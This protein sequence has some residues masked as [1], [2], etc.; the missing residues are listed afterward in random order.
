MKYDFKC[1]VCGWI[2]EFH[3]PMV[4]VEKLKP[5]CTSCEDA[6]GPIK[7]KRIWSAPSVHF[8]GTGWTKQPKRKYGETP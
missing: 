3:A 7:M 4:D 1:P 6:D 8:K 2:M 5:I